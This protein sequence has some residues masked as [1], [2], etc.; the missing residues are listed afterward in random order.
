MYTRHVKLLVSSLLLGWITPSTQSSNRQ[1]FIKCEEDKSGNFQLSLSVT[2]NTNMSWEA[3]VQSHKLLSS[4]D[5]FSS[6]PQVVQTVSDM[7]TVLHYV[8]SCAICIGNN[9]EK[10]EPLVSSR[11]GNFMDSSGMYICLHCKL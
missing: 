10:F 1:C 4:C 11:K 7:K 6:L 8:D 2:I 5:V 3:S 9:D